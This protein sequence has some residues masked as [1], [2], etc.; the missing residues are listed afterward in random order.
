[1]E[2]EIA[3]ISD[4]PRIVSLFLKC[5]KISYSDV[6]SQQARDDMSAEKATELWKSAASNIE[7]KT[8]L[9]W[10]NGVFVGFF[11]IG[12]DPVNFERGHLF[13]LYISP[14]FA[15]KGFGQQLL[16]E[17]I[18][19]TVNEEIT[20]MSLWVFDDNKIAKSLYSKRGFVATGKQKI[21][22]GWNAVEIEMLNRNITSQS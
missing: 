15:G 5:W 13:S 22:P 18:R 12:R 19:I 14:D 16:Q 17:A 20:E 7:R 3:D 1:M 11:R 21:T 9:A 2:Y 8:I 4:V 10:N 6:L